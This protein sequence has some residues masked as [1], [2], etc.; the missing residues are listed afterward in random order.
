MVS[1]GLVLKVMFDA[2]HPDDTVKF[3]EA[4]TSNL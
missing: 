3:E 2:L 1:S 4:M